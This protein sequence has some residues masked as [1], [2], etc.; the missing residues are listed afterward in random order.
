MYGFETFHPQYHNRPLRDL[1]L[2]LSPESKSFDVSQG[3]NKVGLHEYESLISQLSA[4]QVSRSP[5]YSG[6]HH[7]MSGGSHPLIESRKCTSPSEW[8]QGLGENQFRSYT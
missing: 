6:G 4:S 8:Q 1:R 7:I 5:D 2:S 3:P